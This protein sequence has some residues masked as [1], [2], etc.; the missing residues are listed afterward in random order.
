MADAQPP[1]LW[2]PEAPAI[3][4]AL[5]RKVVRFGLSVGIGRVEYDYIFW[6][7]DIRDATADERLAL[8]PAD[9][10]GFPAWALGALMFV[11]VSSS[12]VKT[13]TPLT[14]TSASD[15]TWSVLSDFNSSD[16]T[17]EVISAGYQGGGGYSKTTNAALTASGSAKYRLR[18]GNAGS[19][20]GN[21]C[22]IGNA[23]TTSLATA[24]CGIQSASSSSGAPTTNAIGDTGA[25][26]AGGNPGNDTNVGSEE[27]PLN[28]GGGGG[29]AAG[30]S[31]AGSNG[32]DAS[33]APGPGG[34]GG[35]GGQA[36]GGSAGAG[37]NGSGD[38]FD[39]G[40]TDG[41]NYGGGGGRA[42]DASAA[43]NG[44]QGLIVITNNAS[45]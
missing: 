19:G 7:R 6:P 24:L 29:G 22:W 10:R 28:R 14:A 18:E 32:G 23:A 27:E 35:T 15:Q 4:Q 13:V 26:F 11:G 41:S 45:L 12:L 43:G 31:G 44:A 40:A 36:G 17:L 34:T 3:I 20:V 33:S 2:V 1:R 9:L 5:P 30:P 39:G 42:G 38:G 37:G 16:N 25:K 21:A 8:L